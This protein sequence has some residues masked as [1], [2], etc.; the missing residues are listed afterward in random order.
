MSRSHNNARSY[1]ANIVKEVL[2][3][4]EALEVL[5]WEIPLHPS[6]F[7]DLAPTGYH[8]FCSIVNQ[9]E[10]TTYAIDVDLKAWVQISLAQNQKIFGV[11]AL[12]TGGN[13][14]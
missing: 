4:Y 3:D 10:D 6:Y 5:K 11:T 13:R 7:P 1:T 12:A 8:L 14:L 2:Y 9:M